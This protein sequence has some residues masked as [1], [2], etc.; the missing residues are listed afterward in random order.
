MYANLYLK[1]AQRLDQELNTAPIIAEHGKLDFIARFNNQF[2]REDQELAVPKPAILIQFL[3][4]A[5]STKSRGI[6]EG[7]TL[8]VLHVGINS[9]ADD[10]YYSSNRSQAL[11]IDAYMDLV[12]KAMQ[13]LQ[14]DCIGSL[15]RVSSAEDGNHDHIFVQTMTYKSSIIDNTASKAAQLTEKDVDVTV[16]REKT[17]VTPKPA[18]PYVIP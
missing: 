13:G 8:I 17:I 3:D 7:D 6:Q 16:V 11:L 18:T 12:H 9:I 4:T 15:D 1:I 2:E 14:A 10:N 5:W